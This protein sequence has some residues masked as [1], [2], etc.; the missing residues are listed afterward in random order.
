MECLAVED[1]E[2]KRQQVQIGP[3]QSMFLMRWFGTA[4][5]FYR[6]VY[7]ARSRKDFGYSK[8]KMGRENLVSQKLVNSARR[9]TKIPRLGLLHM[10]NKAVSVPQQPAVKNIW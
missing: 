4:G 1:S 10:L 2:T 9:S 6:R 7:V 5:A 3:S 8:K